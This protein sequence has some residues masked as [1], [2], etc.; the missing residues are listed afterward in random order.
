MN[1]ISKCF[2]S[3][4]SREYEVLSFGNKHNVNKM[5]RKKW[6]C[7][8]IIFFFVPWV[9]LVKYFGYNTNDQ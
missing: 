1:S 5:Q 8:Q 4:K 9:D 3:G 7:K 2:T 6:H